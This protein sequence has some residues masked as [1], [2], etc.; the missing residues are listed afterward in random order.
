MPKY[1]VCIYRH[2][3]S[4]AADASLAIN[5]VSDD[6]EGIFNYSA[7]HRMHLN[8]SKTKALPPLDC[9]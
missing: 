8:A 4:S 1:V 7:N 3:T 2:D 5:M 6:L 9:L